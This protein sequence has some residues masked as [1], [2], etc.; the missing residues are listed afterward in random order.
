MPALDKRVDSAGKKFF[1]TGA[2]PLMNRRQN[3]HR[4]LGTAFH[5]AHPSVD[6]RRVNPIARGRVSMEGVGCIQT[7]TPQCFTLLL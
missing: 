5:S 3:L 6:Q 1:G 2:Q 7:A 4:R